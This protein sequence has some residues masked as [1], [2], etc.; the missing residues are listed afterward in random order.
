MTPLEALQEVLRTEH[1]A[2]YGY[3]VIAAQTSGAQRRTAL[4]ALD[5]HR[6]RRDH[7]RAMVVAAD[8]TPVESAPAYRLP[9]PVRTPQAAVRLAADTEREIALALGALIEAGRSDDRDFAA[10]ALQETAVR[11]TYWR[12]TAPVLPGLPRSVEASASPAP[13]S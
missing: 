13:T 8:G 7:L 2:V 1:A 6:A 9:E 5:T 3:G 12:G 4:N 10:H 11:E